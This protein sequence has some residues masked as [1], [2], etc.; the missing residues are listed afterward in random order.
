MIIFSNMVGLGL[1]L[2][3]GFRSGQSQC[4]APFCTVNY[5]NL[6]KSGTRNS[7]LFPPFRK[8][9]Q[10]KM[11]VHIKHATVHNGADVHRN[12]PKTT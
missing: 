6:V 2:E 7:R 11:L 8:L 9:Y 1:Q 4:V 10:P 12:L 3:L 5:H